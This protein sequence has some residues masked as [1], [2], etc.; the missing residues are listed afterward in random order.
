M[1][2]ETKNKKKYGSIT[3]KQGLIIFL[4]IIMIGILT[5]GIVQL[6]LLIPSTSKVS[7]E[8]IDGHWNS[9]LTTQSFVFNTKSNIKGLEVTFSIRDKKNQELQTITKIIGDVKKGQQ[10]TVSFNITELQDFATLMDSNYTQLSVT[11]GTKKLI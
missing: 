5:F 9:T 4:S 7:N 10:Y 11:G 2:E 1:V 6:L 8:D 3:I